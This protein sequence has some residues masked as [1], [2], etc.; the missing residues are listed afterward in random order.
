MRSNDSTVL[1]VSEHCAVSAGS[2]YLS[3]LEGA[4]CCVVPQQEE[5][6]GP[7]AESGTETLSGILNWVHHDWFCRLQVS[8]RTQAVIIN[9]K[10]DFSAGVKK[11]C[12]SNGVV[13]K[14][15]VHC[16]VYEGIMK[17]WCLHL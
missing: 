3:L 7:L 8:Q 17:D 10:K 13:R 15:R 14:G 12:S 16:S 2:N 6:S 4:R 5:A 11:P 9:K 1:R